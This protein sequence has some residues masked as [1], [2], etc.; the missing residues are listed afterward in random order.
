MPHTDMYYAAWLVPEPVTVVVGTSST[1]PP[2]SRP[3]AEEAPIVQLFKI[4]KK[5]S[6]Q[7]ADR[8]RRVRVESDKLELF[9]G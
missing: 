4:E 1:N 5:S 3:C 2:F 6:R 7:E 9:P 8:R